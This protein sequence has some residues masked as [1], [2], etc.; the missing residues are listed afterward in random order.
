MDESEW[1][2]IEEVVGELQAE[3]IRGLLE[4]QNIQVWLSQ[5]G[6]GRSIYPV[7]ISPLGKVQI[8]VPSNQSQEARSILE[9]YYSGKLADLEYENS[10]DDVPPDQG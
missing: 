4:A 1:V 5:E 6:V 10:P 2:L 7:N 9:E 8:L 3:L